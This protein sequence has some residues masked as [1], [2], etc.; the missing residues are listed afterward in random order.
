[1]TSTNPQAPITQHISAD[2][3]KLVSKRNLELA[4]ARLMRAGDPTYKWFYRPSAVVANPIKTYL[5]RRL[6]QELKDNRFRPDHVSV[7][8]TP[9]PNGLMRHRSLLSIGDQLVYQAVANVIASKLYKK[10]HNQYYK[11]IFGN[12]YA[13]D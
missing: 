2:F 8:S 1:M 5:F 4:W 11:T 3:K 12:L 9:K 6:R 10:T 13:G 7:I